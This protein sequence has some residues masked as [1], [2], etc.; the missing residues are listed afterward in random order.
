M[1]AFA[2]N[3]ENGLQ[4]MMDAFPSSLFVDGFETGDHGIWSRHV[5]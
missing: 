5:P 4:K 1:T 3:V 2:I